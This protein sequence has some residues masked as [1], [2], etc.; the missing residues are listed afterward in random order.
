MPYVIGKS[1]KQKKLL[2]RLDRCRALLHQTY[3]FPFLLY[4][5]LPF[6]LLF[7]FPHLSAF[8]SIFLSSHYQFSL[9]GYASTRYIRPSLL[10]T[11]F[12]SDTSFH[13]V[14]TTSSSCYY[15]CP[16]PSFLSCLFPS[17]ALT[18][19]ST[20]T[21]P[22][23]Q[24]TPNP[25]NLSFSLSLIWTSREFLACARRY[26]LPLGDFPNVDQYRKMLREVKFFSI[27]P[28]LLLLLL[29]LLLLLLLLANVLLNSVWCCVLWYHLD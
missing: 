25:I 7:F 22:H 4:F 8:L 23:P 3:F 29:Q 14:T 13:L 6:F 1:E 15:C 12:V 28:L 17:P 5:Y 9:S 2:D 19:T 20:S 26:N 10:I 11:C 16:L 21:S 27:S 18:S 24:V